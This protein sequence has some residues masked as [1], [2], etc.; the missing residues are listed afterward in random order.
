MPV[1]VAVNPSLVREL[2]DSLN[3]GP[4]LNADGLRMLNEEQ[5]ARFE[6]L[7]VQIQADEHPP[8]HFHVRGRG[9]SVS[10]AID[11]GLR[12][13]GVKGL[14]RYDRNVEKWWRDNRCELILTWNR[15]RPADCPVGTVPVPPEC[16]QP[17]E[18]ADA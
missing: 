7:S 14:E 10:F 13:P 12:L 4:M 8:P 5:V 3:M 9:E 11:T 6:G 16:Q 2:E 17:Q 1:T 18:E 15:L